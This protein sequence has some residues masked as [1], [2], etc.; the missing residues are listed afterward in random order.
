MAARPKSIADL[1]FVVRRNACQRLQGALDSGKPELIAVVGRRRVGK[2]YLIRHFL[3]AHM[4][5]EL[6]GSRDAAMS[7]QLGNFATALGEQLRIR[8][9]HPK[10]WPA[11]FQDLI[12]YLEPLLKKKG[13]RV[14]FFST[15]CPGWR[16]AIPAFSAPLNSSGTSG[17]PGSRTS[18][19]S[20]VDRRLR[21]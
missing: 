8:P 11:A 1:P 5:F 3:A 16:G 7:E 10:N 4:C 13:R 17:L 19:W 20:S 15:N 2:T 12:R 18:S 9:E 21:G 14:I 6:S